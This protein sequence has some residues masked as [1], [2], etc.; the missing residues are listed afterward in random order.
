[1]FITFEGPE[2]GGKSTQI[3]RLASELRARGR[4]V[5]VTR[6]P[7]GSAIGPTVRQ[8]L[9]DS[10][11]VNPLTELFL[12]L[13]DRAAHVSDVIR[14][15]LQSGMVVLCDRY[16]DSTVVYQGY[17]RGGDVE[18]LRE[19]NARATKGLQP[20]LTLLLDLDPVVGSARQQ[21]QDRLDREPLEFHQRVR[22]GFLAE[23][24][25]APERY[26]VID[27]AQHIDEVARL[28]LA[29]VD[30]AGTLAS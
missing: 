7:G 19:L 22:A 15:A 8:L 16:A 26:R 21:S 14:P 30:A 27:A 12:F 28:I 29:E 24:A 17:A 25:R 9:L 4:E 6:E 23:A 18:W 3:Q 20:H 2:G 1:M 11:S 13:A 5:L 10:E